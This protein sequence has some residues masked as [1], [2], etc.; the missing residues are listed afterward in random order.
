VTGESPR[1]VAHGPVD[2][3]GGADNQA[4]DRLANLYWLSSEPIVVADRASRVLWANRSASLFLG[5]P[6]GDLVGLDLDAVI[7]DQFERDAGQ[8]S[9]GDDDSLLDRHSAAC[10]QQSD[11]TAAIPVGE[12]PPGELM[13][14]SLGDGSL[15]AS[16]DQAITGEA[17]S[18]SHNGLSMREFQVVALIGDGAGNAQ[19]SAALGIADPT[20]QQYT[21]TARKKLGASSRA[22]LI[23][24]AIGEG[25]IEPKRT[26]VSVLVA[27]LRN[28]PGVASGLKVTY[29]SSGHEPIGLVAASLY[30]LEFQV[31]PEVGMPGSVDDSTGTPGPWK[32]TALM[33]A[34]AEVFGPG[35][36]FRFS[37]FGGGLVWIEIANRA[38]H[39]NGAGRV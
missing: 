35:S 36:F 26:A 13:V 10:L 8:L 20:V 9:L 25:I 7:T 16:P 32:P 34:F 30:G 21:D 3:G 1:E 4:L 39:R 33:K 12:S 27:A 28:D 11:F 23:S 24:R 5:I 38:V 17:F 2:S 37:D 31:P 29:G 6:N 19:V 18:G 14:F 15:D 22:E